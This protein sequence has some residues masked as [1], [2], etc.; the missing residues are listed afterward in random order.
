MPAIAWPTDWPTPVGEEYET[1]PTGDEDDLYGWT[2]VE[3]PPL[4][5]GADAVHAFRPDT[6]FRPDTWAAPVD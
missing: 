1:T 2:V 6:R 5:A 3:Y 4:A